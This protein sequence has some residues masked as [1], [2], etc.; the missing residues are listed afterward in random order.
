MFAIDNDTASTTLPPIKPVGIPGFFTAGTVGGVPA[1]IV[2]ADFLNQVQQELLAVLAAASI[3]PSKSINT[4]VIQAIL[5][6]IANNT[7]QRLTG[8]LNLYVNGTTGNDTNN[9]LT[10]STT[11]ATPQAAWNYILQRLDVGGQ[12]ITVNMADGSY[13][14]LFC[15]GS[16]VG[17]AEGSAVSFIGDTV[18]P[19]S[20]VISNPNGIAVYA[21]LGAYVG[22]QGVRI[23][24]GGTGGDYN[25]NGTG[26]VANT[27]GYIGI[28]NVDFG[29]CTGSHMVAQ[30]GGAISTGGAPYSI[31]GNA[32]AHCCAAFSGGG[33]SLADSTVTLYNTP[34]FSIGFA[35]ASSCGTMNVW[36]M[37]FNGGAH[38][39][40]YFAETN[41][42]ISCN[43]GNPNAYFP[44]DV[45][46]TVATGGQIV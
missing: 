28:S 44:G 7:R 38:G 17:A 11:F 6:L 16:P 34:T 10:P 13:P 4:Q 46:G 45:N 15:I 19:S 33:M 3:S 21:A 40:R 31:S 27:G 35:F 9:G 2:E 37:H 8:P 32:Q 22:L 24:A 39:P 23:Q 14:A 30:G 18:S 26:L 20:V 43:V 1:T 5:W 25:A 12:S 29:T 42:I 36:S 41:G